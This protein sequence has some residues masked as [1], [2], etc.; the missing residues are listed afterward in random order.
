M[1][2]R[3]MRRL[4]EE[5]GK[6]AREESASGESSGEE[7]T[8]SPPAARNLFDLLDDGDGD[9]DQEE[10]E[11]EEAEEET[12]SPAIAAGQ[13]KASQGTA[14][15]LEQ[16]RLGST[17]D[18]VAGKSAP[19]EARCQES[20]SA[21]PKASQQPAGKKAGKS[22]SKSKG[23]G[24]GKAK[25]EGKDRA[26][27]GDDVDIDL[28]LQR[29]NAD[30][31]ETGEAQ[32]PLGKSGGGTDPSPG[33]AAA[34]SHHILAANPQ[35]LKAEDELRRI[36]GS[37]IVNS[38]ESRRKPGHHPRFARGRAGGAAAVA[39]RRLRKGLLV[40]PQDTWPPWDGGLSMESLG[41][42]VFQFK[43]S[44]AYKEVQRQY[45]S[46]VATH[47]PNTIATLVA[48]HPYHVDSLLA[49][50]EVYKQMGEMQTHAHLLER[51]LY[52]L[53]CGW[54]PWFNPALGTCRLD[55][56]IEENRS[57]FYCLSRHIQQLGRR[58]C[59]TTAFECCKLLLSLDPEDPMG[60]LQSIDFFAIRSH[61]YA[62]LE[63]MATEFDAKSS[64]S[65]LPNF[66]F[67]LALARLRIEEQSA[68][69]AATKSSSTAATSS[70]A[71]GKGSVAASHSKGSTGAVGGG[72]G[73]GTGGDR[74]SPGS[75]ALMQQALCLH[76]YILARLMTKV[77]LKEDA[78]W[79][80][81]LK[82]PFFAKAKVPNPSLE[83]LVGIFLERQHT[84]WKAAEVQ[85]WLKQAAAAVLQAVDSNSSL[86]DGSSPQDWECVRK[87]AFPESAD[88]LYRHLAVSDFSDTLNAL[89]PE[90]AAGILPGRGG[91]AFA[92]GMGG[93][94]PGAAGGRGLFGLGGG[95]GGAEPALDVDLEQLMAAD[96]RELMERLR[97]DG[98]PEEL[99]QGR[100][101]SAL[102]H[103][104]RSLLPWMNYGN[105][106]RRGGANNHPDDDD[107]DDNSD[108]VGPL[109]DDEWAAQAEAIAQGMA[110]P[111]LD[112]RWGAGGQAG[113]GGSRGGGTG[114]PDG[115]SGREWQP[116]QPG[117][118]DSSDDDMPDIVSD[119]NDDSS[120]EGGGA[121]GG[122]GNAPPVARARPDQGNGGG[123]GRGTGQQAHGEKGASSD[124]SLPDMLVTSDDDN[125]YDDSV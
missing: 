58:G 70:S 36:F 38:E 106:A 55:F 110:D 46:C 105:L 39:A 20:V 15:Q 16:L 61:H 97:R 86:A 74:G 108:E 122:G 78:E 88:N 43:H 10:E 60:A 89:P 111:L 66:A 1:S 69:S 90:E 12:A 29:I 41:N 13:P 82:H 102:V 14:D 73:A 37:R 85:A 54:H 80:R 92:G 65:L 68:M 103:F 83:R 52:A 17:D 118:G 116:P 117:W 30:A 71:A 6:E 72:K 95:G 84:L 44:P 32:A 62:Y 24:K 113:L 104:L 23:K 5:M 53:E 76:P 120:D 2:T 56:R 101:M 7:A 123:N 94:G 48:R 3:M 45:E 59:H 57:F 99:L 93:G 124:D 9:L 77:A 31:G 96:E 100:E 64:L 33:K 91:G 26:G 49:L 114:A 34:S 4:R 107:D 98:M 28:V 125:G 75:G 112:H 42:N 40:S 109:D 79:G 63:A 21:S 115:G 8:A 27:A 50:A 87:E 11:Q 81:V 18:N 51:C 119:D 25:E 35:H 121:G 22:K 47:D 67:S 19:K